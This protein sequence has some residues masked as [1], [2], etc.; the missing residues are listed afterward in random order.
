MS[1]EVTKLVALCREAPEMLRPRFSCC[2]RCGAAIVCMLHPFY[3]IFRANKT[4]CFFLGVCFFYFAC[5]ALDA[6]LRVCGIQ[7]RTPPSERTARCSVLCES[8]DVQPCFFFA[9]GC[10]SRLH[11][12]DWRYVGEPARTREAIRALVV[13]LFEE[14]WMPLLTRG[15][16]G[17]PGWHVVVLPPTSDHVEV[18]ATLSRRSLADTPS[19]AS[20]LIHAIHASGGAAEGHLQQHSQ[21]IGAG[22]SGV[23]DTGDVQ[24]R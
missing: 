19:G 16:K 5:A 24:W 21:S 3:V 2:G 1:R 4:L 8:E 7:R 12:S 18:I 11:F 6:L 15:G 13:R 23:R 10:A 9:R 22:R 17:F 14:R 20:A